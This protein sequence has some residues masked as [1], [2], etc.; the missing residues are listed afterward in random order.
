VNAAAIAQNAAVGACEATRGGD[1]D[2][3][4]DVDDAIDGDELAAQRVDELIDRI[5]RSGAYGGPQLL[6]IAAAERRTAARATAERLASGSDRL[7]IVRRGRHAVRRSLATRYAQFDLA[8]V[9]GTSGDLSTARDRVEI[10]MA[11]E[12]LVLATAVED[13]LPADDFAALATDGANL[14]V[15][16]PQR[17]SFPSVYYAPPETDEG[18]TGGSIR[19]MQV[20]VVAILLAGSLIAGAILGFIP[21]LFGGCLVASIVASWIWRRNRHDASDAA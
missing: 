5:R 13:L 11:L 14:L 3:D 7:D 16:I 15:D 19:V 21:A 17:T 1:G 6:P 4:V 2:V 9:Y 12:D 10:A 8:M 20:T 18:S